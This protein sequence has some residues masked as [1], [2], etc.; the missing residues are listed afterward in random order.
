V[1]TLRNIYDWLTPG[2]PEWQVFHDDCVFEAVIVT[3]PTGGVILRYLYRGELYDE[4]V[5][6]SRADARRE[7]EK[8]HVK[9]KAI[10]WRKER[11][12]TTASQRP[13]MRT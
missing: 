1:W 3:D 12:S 9:L 6:A 10:G 4:Q 11:T 13:R 7:A 5:F 8:V 2:H